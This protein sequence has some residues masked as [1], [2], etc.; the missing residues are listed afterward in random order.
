MLATQRSKLLVTPRRATRPPMASNVAQSANT[1]SWLKSSA[2]PRRA[3]PSTLWVKT[4]PTTAAA[5][6][7]A[8][9]STMP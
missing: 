2:R 5:M 3:A 6:I 7:K 1:A 4:Q 8:G 9:A